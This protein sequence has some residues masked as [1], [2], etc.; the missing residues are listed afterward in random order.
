[1][2]NYRDDFKIKFT[3]EPNFIVD[4]KNKTVKCYLEGVVITPT[5]L[6]GNRFMENFRM[7]AKGYAKCDDKD[8]FDPQVG[9]RI[10]LARAES[11]LYWKVRTE[12]KRAKRDAEMLIQG[13]EK[14]I[15][16]AE[17]VNLHN[18]YY[19]KHVVQPV[20]KSTSEILSDKAKSQS[21]DE[22]GRFTACT[23]TERSCEKKSEKTNYNKQFNNK[24][25]KDNSGS[26]VIKIRIN[27]I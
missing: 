25:C 1:M 21:R 17:R 23:N 16:K 5:G 2:K 27:R 15:A 10:A 8:N 4:E 12:V 24:P 18:E 19:V 6:S 3:K 13:A 7:F 22:K 14:F 9:K 26:A 20:R 11:R